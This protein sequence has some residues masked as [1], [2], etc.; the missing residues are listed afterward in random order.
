MARVGIAFG[1]VG[2]LVAA[3]DLAHKAGSEAAYI[4]P[5][6]SAY[7]LV[8]AGLVAA[9]SGAILLA[10]SLSIAISAGVVAG[11]AVGNLASLAVWPGVPNPIVVDDLAFNLADTFVL[12]GFVLTVCAALAFAGRNRDRLRQPLSVSATEF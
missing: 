12:A 10:R 11:G 5:R 6:S 2:V 8:V 3:I 1:A 7:A 4:H 9:W